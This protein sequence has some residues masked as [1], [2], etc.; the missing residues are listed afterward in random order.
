MI[1]NFILNYNPFLR[2]LFL[3]GLG[4]FALRNNA[5]R[6]HCSRP[7]LAYSGLILLATI[8][9]AAIAMYQRAIAT[10]Q[11]YP[12][13]ISLLASLIQT[14]VCY[15]AY[16]IICIIFICKRH[17]HVAFL[18]GIADFD[19]HQIFSNTNNNP[20]RYTKL[21][22]SNHFYYKRFAETS[23]FACSSVALMMTS[24]YVVPD[25][26][27][28]MTIKT[29]NYLLDIM[30]VSMSLI[31]FHIRACAMA[32]DGRQSYI[33]NSMMVN[34]RSCLMESGKCSIAFEQL[35]NLQQ[36]R[37]KFD[38]LF[39]VGILINSAFDL[40]LFILSLNMLVSLRLEHY[41]WQQL[42]LVMTTFFLCPL[43]KTI[44]LVIAMEN[45]AERVRYFYANMI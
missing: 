13:T 43:I 19:H 26:I 12:P 28:S 29:L 39:G 20:K 37:V 6:V 3:V 8:P 42:Q 33:V 4:P 24:N 35:G 10:I 16:C 2:V 7:A 1:H 45:L 36:L 9:I 23:I 22:N 38:D 40:V 21:I 41:T 44:M 32:L 11:T 34:S 31:I 15:S 14:I 30:L 18:N 5:A 25:P 27:G 17:E